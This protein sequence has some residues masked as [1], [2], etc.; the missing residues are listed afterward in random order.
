MTCRLDPHNDPNEAYEV[1]QTPSW[2]RDPLNR[3]VDG[4][5]ERPPS[6]T[7]PAPS[8][9]SCYPVRHRPGVPRAAACA[10]LHLDP[11]ARPWPI[12]PPAVLGDQTLEPHLAGR[13]EQIRPNLTALERRHEDTLRPPAQECVNRPGV[14]T[15][16]GELS[17]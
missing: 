11:V 12:T 8:E 1:V 5:G 9:G 13:V 17:Y 7:L 3:L 14:P 16:I 4:V 2:L 6:Q 15:P 10:V